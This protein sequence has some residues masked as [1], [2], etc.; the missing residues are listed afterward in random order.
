M[1]L[2]FSIM[3]LLLVSPR[4][5]IK[6]SNWIVMQMASDV[7]FSYATMSGKGCV[8]ATLAPSGSCVDI[9]AEVCSHAHRSADNLR[10]GDGET[11]KTGATTVEAIGCSWYLFRDE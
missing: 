6:V 7:G 4:D 3:Q 10:H 2:G 8:T 1:Q 5:G 9:V 11:E